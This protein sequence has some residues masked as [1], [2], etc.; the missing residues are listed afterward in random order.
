MNP[1]TALPNPLTSYVTPTLVKTRI[2]QH[3]NII[4]LQARLK[5][6]SSVTISFQSGFGLISLSLQVHQDD[7][8]FSVLHR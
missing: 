6:M 2:A 4:I 7:P 8:M 3:H 1:L 5:I